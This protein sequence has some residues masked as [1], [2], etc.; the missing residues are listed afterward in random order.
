MYN[1]L[2][3]LSALDNEYYNRNRLVQVIILI[4]IMPVGILI[5]NHTQY[6]HNI[7]VGTKITFFLYFH[8][9]T[10]VTSIMFSSH[11]IIVL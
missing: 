9:Q 5:L 2:R 4:I 3:D 7:M 8:R 10:A 11:K 6:D 1:F